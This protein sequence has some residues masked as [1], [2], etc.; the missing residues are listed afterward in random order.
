MAEVSN[1]RIRTDYEEK[2]ADIRSDSHSS[3]AKDG[4]VDLAGSPDNIV[5]EYDVHET[6]RIMR[7][8]DYRLIPLLSILYLY[9]RAF[10]DEDT[11]LICHFRL[12]YIDRSNIGNARIAGMYEDLQLQGDRYNVALTV[13]FVP[14]SLFEVSYIPCR[15][16]K[17]KAE[18]S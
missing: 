14:Y 7:K 6:R 2:A 3:N 9:A 12:A 18:C 8:I 13:F 10:E 4:H 1:E 11:V 17:L 5:H 16:R 15:A